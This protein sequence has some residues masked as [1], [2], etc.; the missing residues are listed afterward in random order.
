MGNATTVRAA[1]FPSFEKSCSASASV[2]PLSQTGRETSA[3]RVRVK[4]SSVFWPNDK[5]IRQRTQAERRQL[6]R[7]IADMPAK[8]QAAA[9]TLTDVDERR[10]ADLARSVIGMSTLGQKLTSVSPRQP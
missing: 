3:V 8:G 1:Q 2:R 10:E 5:L 7:A 6:Q 4:R 9:A